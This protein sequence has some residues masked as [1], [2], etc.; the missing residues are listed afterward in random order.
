MGDMRSFVFV[1]LV[2][3]GASGAA[4]GAVQHEPPDAYEAPA[5]DAREA[6]PI[7]KDA[8]GGAAAKGGGGRIQL[9]KIPRGRDAVVAEVRAAL[10]KGAWEIVKDEASPSG[11]AIRIAAKKD[12]KTWKASFTGDAKQTSLI[13]TRPS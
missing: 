1:V 8:G 2:T 11:S 13:L 5:G 10:D 12:G 3:V 6:F 7:P 4:L 9:Y